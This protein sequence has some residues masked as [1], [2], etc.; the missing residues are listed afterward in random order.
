MLSSIDANS[1]IVKH[2]SRSDK[3]SVCKKYEK[4]DGTTDGLNAVEM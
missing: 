2:L 4:H 1:T 3:N